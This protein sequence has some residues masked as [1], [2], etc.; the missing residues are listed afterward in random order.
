MAFAPLKC[1][2]AK[3]L[4]GDNLLCVD[5]D[6]VT[7]LTDQTPVGWNFTANMANCWQISGY[8]PV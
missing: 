8:L 5:F 1:A 3:G 2:A 6:K 7:Q 4:A